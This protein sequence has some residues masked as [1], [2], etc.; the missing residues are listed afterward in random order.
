MPSK[1]SEELRAEIQKLRN[2]IAELEAERERLK[3]AAG[4]VDEIE[5]VK[6]ALRNT[7]VVVFTHDKQLRYNRVY[8]FHPD[9][10]PE[11]MLGKTD[12]DLFPPEQARHIMEIKRRVLETGIEAHEETSVTIAGANYFY[13]KDAFPIRDRNGDITGLA[14]ACLNITELRRAE[15]ALRESEERCRRLSERVGEGPAKTEEMRRRAG[16]NRRG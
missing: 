5:I 3:E 6:L 15:E 7:P 12:A 8:T 1:E 14:C 10:P 4:S 13:Y 16:R 11:A 9:L 2:R